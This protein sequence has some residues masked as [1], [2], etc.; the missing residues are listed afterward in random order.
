MHVDRARLLLPLLLRRRLALSAAG[1]EDD[2]RD[3]AAGCER[4][5]ERADQDKPPVHF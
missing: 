1:G 4:G 2:A 5:H 3:G